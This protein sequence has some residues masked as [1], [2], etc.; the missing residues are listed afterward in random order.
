MSAAEPS[1]A[2][3]ASPPRADDDALAR[4]IAALPAPTPRAAFA[5]LSN[6]DLVARHRLGVECF[7]RRVFSLTDAQL[8]MAFLPDAGVGRWPCRVLLGH[9]AD[10][11]VENV[12]RMRRTVAEDQPML[13]AWDEN[14]FID[15][16]LYGSD[17]P[18]RPGSR[19]PIGAFVAVIHTLRQ[20]SSQWLATLPE[21]AWVRKALHPERGEITVRFIAEYN[22]WH[23]ENHAWFL[24]RKVARLLD[25]A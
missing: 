12:H 17:H 23:L 1:H 7:D 18:D 13:A 24:N 6:S 4:R 19:H 11:E 21:S 16:G 15:A 22:A 20:W 14:A 3:H 9:V 10:A 25:R 8:D 2:H 5:S